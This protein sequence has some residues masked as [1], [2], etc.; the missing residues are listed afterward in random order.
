[1]AK[2]KQ[3]GIELVASMPWSI[4]IVLGLVG[5]IAIRHGIGW[6]FSS[7][8]NPYTS[9]LGRLAATGMYAPIGWMLLIG[10]WIAAINSFVG[11]G[12]RRQL[13]D[14]LASTACAR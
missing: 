8:S 7:L 3:S 12:R 9:G 13:L 14:K 10:C 2:R 4:G 11:R 1:M 6:Y 5:Y